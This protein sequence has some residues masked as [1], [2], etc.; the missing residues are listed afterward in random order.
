MLCLF[1]FI[2]CAFFTLN[3]RKANKKD[4]ILSDFSQLRL[5]LSLSFTVFIM[6]FMTLRQLILPNDI[7]HIFFLFYY[8]QS[9]IMKSGRSNKKKLKNFHTRRYFRKIW[10]VQ[11][12]FSLHLFHYSSRLLDLLMECCD[13]FLQSY[14]NIFK[15]VKWYWNYIFYV[16]I[17]IIIIT[18]HNFVR[19]VNTFFLGWNNLFDKKRLFFS[20]HKT[21]CCFFGTFFHDLHF[22]DF[23]FLRFCRQMCAY[24]NDHFYAH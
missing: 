17:V 22:Y 19:Y 2:P 4:T 23:A 6:I 9:S 12:S 21:L 13:N 14:I 10:S 7:S 16:S 8:F 18:R 3:I 20:Y 1:C 24:G 5:S 11:S 15:G